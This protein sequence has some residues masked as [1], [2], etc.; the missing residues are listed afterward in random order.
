MFIEGIQCMGI[1]L[2]SYELVVSDYIGV[3]LQ[4]MNLL[5]VPVT[6]VQTISCCSTLGPNSDLFHHVNVL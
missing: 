4:S 6:L 5:Y 1:I 3:N 2:Y